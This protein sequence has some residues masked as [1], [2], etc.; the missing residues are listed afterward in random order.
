MTEFG[1]TV[2]QSLR[3]TID[4]SM[5]IRRR[6]RT[7]RIEH[8]QSVC[9]PTP[10]RS[11]PRAFNLLAFRERDRP[12][13]TT[14]SRRLQTTPTEA[15]PP[16]LQ[17]NHAIV[18][19]TRTTRSAGLEAVERLHVDLGEIMQGPR[20]PVGE[21]GVAPDEFRLASGGDRRQENGEERAE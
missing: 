15:L 2:R 20:R 5:V 21:V 4:A 9:I 10:L 3:G 19:E 13:N 17:A 12:C 11:V 6:L 16:E 14:R 18:P 7:G 8:K 1:V